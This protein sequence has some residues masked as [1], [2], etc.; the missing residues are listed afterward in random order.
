MKTRSN[1]EEPGMATHIKN[2]A[3]CKST[4]A[5]SLAWTANENYTDQVAA[6]A[7]YKSNLREVALVQAKDGAL[8]VDSNVMANLFVRPH[9]NLMRDIEKLVNDGAIDR[10]KLEPIFYR[11]SYDRPQPAYR[12]T[13]RDALVLM[14][15]IGGKKATE[16]QA[17]LVDEFLR[18]RT[19]LRRIA[20]RKADPVLKLVRNEKG[21]AAT[22]MTDCLVDARGELGKATKDHHFMNEH[23][24]CNLVLTGFRGSIDE[25]DLEM[26]SMRRLA[27]IRRR[28]AVLIL[29]GL[30]YQQRKA[31]LLKEYSLH[32]EALI[33]HVVT[34]MLALEAA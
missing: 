18:M 4:T 6:L 20:S 25:H 23:L 1:G 24:L 17:K 11:D 33:S 31:E 16:G 13:E 9:K 21:V 29:K 32:Q 19:E 5:T 14:P 2:A 30:S 22:L 3:E 26:V 8:F 27:K 15:F 7:T 12:L 10:L 34:N 28:N